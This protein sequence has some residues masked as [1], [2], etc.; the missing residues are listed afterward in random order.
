MGPWAL[1]SILILCAP[2]F[3]AATMYMSLG[4]TIQSLRGNG[5]AIV[6]PRWMTC[7]FVIVDVFCL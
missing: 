3:I 4:R 2:P 7:L 1:Q 5:Y 6:I